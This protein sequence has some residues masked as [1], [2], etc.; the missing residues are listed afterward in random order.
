MAV[1]AIASASTGHDG[2]EIGPNISETS[3]KPSRLVW[4]YIADAF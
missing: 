1:L 4:T 3:F 2:L